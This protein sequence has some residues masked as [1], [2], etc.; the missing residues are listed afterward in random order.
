MFSL[1]GNQ[2]QYLSCFLLS[3][4]LSLFSPTLLSFSFYFSPIKKLTKISPPQPFTSTSAFY[5][6]SYS[7]PQFSF[8][9]IFLPL[10][11]NR[12]SP[13]DLGQR[14]MME[15]KSPRFTHPTTTTSYPQQHHRIFI[16]VENILR[17]L[18]ILL[19][20][21]SVVVTVTNHQTVYLFDTPLEAHFY[22]SSSFK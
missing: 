5:S 15:P 14:F 16:M 11:P 17:I 2:R 3:F 1:W 9:S 13:C 12:S 21:A 10:F 22:Y 7:S 6:A 8:L 18:A 4:T 19:S 20:A